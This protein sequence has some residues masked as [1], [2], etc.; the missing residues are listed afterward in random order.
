MNRARDD[1]HWHVPADGVIE[2]CEF[3]LAEN[4]G[5]ERDPGVN[6]DQHFKER[7]GISHRY[8]C[9]VRAGEQMSLRAF[10]TFA[11]TVGEHPALIDPRYWSWVDGFA[12]HREATMVR[13]DGRRRPKVKE[14][15]HA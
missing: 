7:Y 8:L 2:W 3:D 5:W 15:A 6:L 14:L 13:V 9:R 12:A 10:E 4:G 1:R 11:E